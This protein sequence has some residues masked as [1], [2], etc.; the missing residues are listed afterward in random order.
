MFCWTNNILQNIPLIK[1]NVRNNPHNIVSPIEQ[2]YEYE[3][4]L[5]INPKKPHVVGNKYAKIERNVND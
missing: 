5:K 4:C 1:L 3:K 2:C